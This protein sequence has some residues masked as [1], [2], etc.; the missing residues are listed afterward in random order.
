VEITDRGYGM[1]SREVQ[2]YLASVTGRP[3]G[4]IDQ[5]TRRAREMLKIPSGPRGLNAPH[6]EVGDA[7][8][9][10]LTLPSRRVGD[11]WD[12]ALKLYDLKMVPHPEQPCLSEAFRGEARSFPVWI[13]IAMRDGLESIGFNI[14]SI[15]MADSGEYAAV[16]FHRRSL[17]NLRFVFT[18]NETHQSADG[19]RREAIYSSAEK[20]AAGN[21]FVLGRAH[22]KMLGDRLAAD[23]PI[24]AIDEIKVDACTDFDEQY[25]LGEA[26]GQDDRTAD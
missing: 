1:R 7:L 26:E 25:F 16:N 21:R 8:F 5:R 19:K 15:E 2:Q 24:D 6:M 11:A 14:N 23:N 3:L 18:G 12:V 13:L 20:L 9:H 10:I 17:K 4:E 22:L